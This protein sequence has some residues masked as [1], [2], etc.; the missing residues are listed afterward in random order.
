MG[1]LPRLLIVALTNNGR[2]SLSPIDNTVVTGIYPPGML[3]I[4]CVEIFEGTSTWHRRQ[5]FTTLAPT[6]EQGTSIGLPTLFIPNIYAIAYIDVVIMVVVA[7]V[8][9][10]KTGNGVYL[11]QSIIHGGPITIVT[12]VEM[13][14]KGLYVVLGFAPLY[15]T[16]GSLRGEHYNI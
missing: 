6:Y 15:F 2:D 5:L 4:V 3:P 1:P 13:L 10:F 7:K 11:I 9:L 14:R 16:V 8:T 12:T